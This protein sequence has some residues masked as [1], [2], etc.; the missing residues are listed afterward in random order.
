M[1]NIQDMTFVEGP[2]LRAFNLTIIKVETAGQTQHHGNAMSLIGVYNSDLFRDQVLERRQKIVSQRNGNTQQDS[3][4]TISKTL[5]SI[6][7]ILLQSNN[8]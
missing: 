8:N 3:I 2:L 4:E 5:V 6:E 7:K 1:E